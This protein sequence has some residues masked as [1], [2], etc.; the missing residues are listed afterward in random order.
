MNIDK[1]TKYDIKKLN[2]RKSGF[3]IIELI[4]TLA[5]SGIILSI[6]V[7]SYTSH[8]NKEKHSEAHFQ[9]EALKI[10]TSQC[11]LKEQALL[12]RDNTNFS[13]CQSGQFNIPEAITSMAA[14]SHI[15]CSQV[16]NG[17][18]KVT[19]STDSDDN[20]AEFAILLEPSFTNRRVVFTSK[21]TGDVDAPSLSCP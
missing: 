4:I 15:I 11:I 1:H 21:E 7:P 14:N 9:A 8:I 13:A 17:E 19:L 2:N 10:P 18:I 3:S 5:I 12:G 6:A 20:D 16:I